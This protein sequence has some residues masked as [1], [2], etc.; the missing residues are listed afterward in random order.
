[1]AE[2]DGVYELENLENQLRTLLNRYSSNDLR[3]EIKSFCSDFCKVRLD[4]E[5]VTSFLSKIR[6]NMLVDSP[7]PE[8]ADTLLALAVGSIAF[9]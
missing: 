5:L 8:L 2:E 7:P 9:D 4:L 1:M 6:A 3:V